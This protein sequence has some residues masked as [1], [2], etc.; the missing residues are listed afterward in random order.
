MTD[1]AVDEV[2]SP[3]SSD[4]GRQ[5]GVL[6]KDLIAEHRVLHLPARST[7][8]EAAEFLAM[9]HMGAI[10]IMSDG[11]LEGIFTERD[12][13]VRVLAAGLDPG[14]T[15]IADVMTREALTV[16]LETPACQAAQTM[17]EN[18]IRHLPVLDG[19]RVIGIVSLRDLVYLIVDQAA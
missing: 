15:L 17:L 18:N 12:A 9:M 1:L 2:T 5:N 7:V 8:R 6:V 11:A 19:G 13:L 10:P 4:Q 16:N 14:S 3:V